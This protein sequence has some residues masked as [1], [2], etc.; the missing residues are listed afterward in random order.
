[1]TSRANSIPNSLKL[2]RTKE[3]TIVQYI[4]DLYVQGSAPRLCKVEDMANKLLDVRNGEPV[5][6]HWAT[7]FVAHQNTLE[8][9]FNQPKDKQRRLQKDPAVI[10]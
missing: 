9:A 10:V 6:K 3:Q 8:M 1:M 4:L 2:T 7:R 5:G